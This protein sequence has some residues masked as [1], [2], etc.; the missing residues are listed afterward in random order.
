MRGKGWGPSFVTPDAVLAWPIH[1]EQFV[2][3][4]KNAL[5]DSR[6]WLSQ[7]H[8]SFPGNQVFIFKLLSGRIQ[9]AKQGKQSRRCDKNHINTDEKVTAEEIWEC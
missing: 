9:S 3:M 4:V 8:N 5:Q 2:R 1:L 7:G 6:K